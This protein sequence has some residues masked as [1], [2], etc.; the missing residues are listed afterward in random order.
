MELDIITDETLLGAIETLRA[1]GKTEL[2]I[3][4]GNAKEALRMNLFAKEAGF[5]KV[6]I[7]DN[8]KQEI[9]NDPALE[10]AY[11][12]INDPKCN[13]NENEFFDICKKTQSQ[14]TQA[15]QKNVNA[16]GKNMK[17]SLGNAG[18]SLSASQA[19]K[20]N[21]GYSDSEIDGDASEV[22]Y[23]KNNSHRS[24][25]NQSDGSKPAEPDI[26]FGQQPT[27]GPGPK[28]H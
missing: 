8:I 24:R 17:R 7:A 12:K 5:T 25:K 22:H 26:T 1:A 4:E 23:Y 2:H 19:T 20:S 15:S 3:E 9:M 27:T 13:I 14:T 6:I 10:D 11:N 21:Y 18:K 28:N 16:I